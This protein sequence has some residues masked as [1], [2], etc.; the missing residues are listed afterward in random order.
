MP[1]AKKEC[2]FRLKGRPP[3]LPGTGHLTV[4]KVVYTL[5]HMYLG[6]R[7]LLMI[8]LARMQRISLVEMLERLPH[9]LAK[10][11]LRRPR[12]GPGS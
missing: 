1:K 10:V 3:I 2:V 5:L 12:P 6:A 7:L 8:P 9:D 4:G 11:S